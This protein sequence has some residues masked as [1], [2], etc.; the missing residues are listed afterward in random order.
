MDLHA[1][2]IY[3]HLAICDVCAHTVE[4]DVQDLIATL[5]AAF[6]VPTSREQ[7]RCKRCGSGS[8][9][10]QLALPEWMSNTG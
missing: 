10:V 9:V 8:C 7:L 4:L 5:G 2:D 1:F 3:R 6:P